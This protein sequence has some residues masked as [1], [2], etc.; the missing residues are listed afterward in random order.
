MEK[1]FY[2]VT[3]GKYSDYHIIAVTDDLAVAEKIAKKF[4]GSWDKAEIEVFNN[5][6]IMLKPA[7]VIGFDGQGTVTHTEECYDEYQYSCLNECFETWRCDYKLGVYVSA[8]DLEA[9]IK[10]ASE[11]RAKYLAE[12]L[13]L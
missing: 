13:G 8:D 1:K 6:E 7:W 12:K 3:R 4:S 9:A 11:K 2:A 10:I 5:A